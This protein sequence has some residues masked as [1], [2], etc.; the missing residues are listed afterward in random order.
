M[1]MVLTLVRRD[2]FSADIE[3]LSL[4]SFT[5]GFSV[6]KGGWVQA[7][8]AEDEASVIE[9]MTLW[10]RGTSHDNLATNL[11]ALDKLLTKA[12]WYKETPERYALWLRAQLT[13]ESHTREAVVLNARRGSVQVFSPPASPGNTIKGY[14]LTLERTP[15]WEGARV[16]VSSTPAIS[17]IGG[18]TDDIAITVGTDPARIALITFLGSSNG[19]LTEYWWGFRTARNGTLANFRSPW[20]LES[21]HATN[22]TTNTT[23]TT[24][25]PGS[26]NTKLNCT[27]TSHPEM[28]LRAYFTLADID[29]TYFEDLRGTFDLILRAK[30]GTGVTSRVQLSYG[31]Y[32]TAP[33]TLAG[34]YNTC[35]PVTITGTSWKLYNIGRVTLPAGG[36][37]YSTKTGMRESLLRIAAEL[38]AG[39]AG[40]DALD[41]DCII[42]IPVDEGYGHIIG[43]LGWKMNVS[44]S[45]IGHV[46]ANE[47]NSAGYIY[48]ITTA[49][50]NPVTCVVP[51]GA[52]RL[53]CAAQ[54]LASSVLEDTLNV[55]A[56]I[57][58]RW[59]TLR[60]DDA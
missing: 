38:V 6:E 14:S 29:A 27:F 59:R 16:A 34:P 31:L 11:V 12:R 47:E 17:G 2:D 52:N 15:L 33:T 13:N 49:D 3:S 32:G 21:G 22:D 50:I 36:K 19:I 35:D 30:C 54:R 4:L 39:S 40:A 41:M 42:P 56:D 25:S 43:G 20:E 9:A 46:T 18:Y 23:D 44:V 24:A 37:G 48:A 10:A 45:P 8:A 7:I 1:A 58:P 55:A 26:G 57:I 51:V 60:G 5:N 28:A 53:Y